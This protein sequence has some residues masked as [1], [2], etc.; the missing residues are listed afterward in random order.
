MQFLPSSSFFLT[1]LWW[2]IFGERVT[3]S[4][5]PWYL[6]RYD[7]EGSETT[8]YWGHWAITIDSK[9]QGGGAHVCKDRQI[10]GSPR[11]CT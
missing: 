6:P 1:V 10:Q 9:P 4:L 3:F 7:K 5:A 11:S 8:I 2:E